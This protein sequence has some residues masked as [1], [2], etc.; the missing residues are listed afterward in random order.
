MHAP[1][2]LFDRAPPANIELEQALLGAI[3]LN[4]E[5]FHRISDLVGPPH[6][7]EP[8]HRKIF[9]VCGDLGR[10]NR[11]ANPIT[12]KSFLPSDCGI[13]SLTMNEYLARLAAEATTVINA[14]DYARE[15]RELASRREMIATAEDIIDGCYGTGAT[16]RTIATGGIERLD[17]IV[18]VCSG[19]QVTRFEIGRAADDAVSRLDDMLQNPGR[20]TGVSWGLTSLDRVVPSLKPGYLTVLAGRP[21]M[22]KTGV[23]LCC[24]VRAARAGHDTL[25]ISLE[26]TAEALANRALTDLA[27]DRHRPIAYF[28]IERGDIDGNEFNRIEDARRILQTIPIVIEEQ[29]ALTVCEIAARA[30]KR[31]Q[32]LERKGRALKLLMVDHVH[33]VSPS[34]R[35]P[36][37]RVNEVGEISAGLK[38]IAKE[39]QI[40]VL[41]LAQLS[42]AVEQR[43]EKRPQLSDLR[44]SGSIEQDADAVIFLYREE[45]YLG[46]PQ[47]GL[48]EAVRLEQLQK[49]EN[50]LEFIVA[51]QRSGPTET[52]R[53]RFDAACNHIDDLAPE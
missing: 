40:P 2:K 13:A 10:K 44:D 18:A 32:E 26:M 45:Y 11:I 16:A 41:A 14:V 19:A 30:R 27:Y 39:L 50:I 48:E 15:I 24:A 53:V 35:Y 46:K 20:R 49:V 17:E 23:A 28:D 38:A 22:G 12:V 7:F 33:I 3:L 52:V 21:G 43:Q 6:F 51:K 47:D 9:E 4:N 36:G 37:S 29:P 5:A 8:I 25:L 42:R 31:Q 1:V 34:N